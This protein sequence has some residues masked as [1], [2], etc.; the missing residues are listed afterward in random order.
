LNPCHLESGGLGLALGLGVKV[1]VSVESSPV[2]SLSPREWG[3]RVSVRFR[4]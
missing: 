4:G 3:V 2:E 1:R